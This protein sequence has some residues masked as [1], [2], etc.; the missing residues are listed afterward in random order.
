[1]ND[2]EPRRADTNE[3]CFLGAVTMSSMSEIG[4]LLYRLTLRFDSGPAIVHGA[5]KMGNFKL[6]IC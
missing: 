5:I 1:M 2:C 6:A 4:P 3:F